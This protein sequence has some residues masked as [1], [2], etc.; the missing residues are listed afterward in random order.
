M[1][2]SGNKLLPEPMLTQIC[3]AIGNN[4]LIYQDIFSMIRCHLYL[5]L[6]CQMGNDSPF[7]VPH[8]SLARFLE[9]DSTHCYKSCRCNKH[10]RWSKCDSLGCVGRDSCLVDTETGDRQDV[11]G[12]YHVNLFEFSSELLVCYTSTGP[13]GMLPAPLEGCRNGNYSET[14]LKR[15]LNFVVSQDRWS[16]MTERI[17]MIL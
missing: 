2:P 14:C 17:N 4:E 11:Q 5:F 15:T 8:K 16:L 1:A 10:N 12:M 6:A 13:S 3:R 9:E 7:L